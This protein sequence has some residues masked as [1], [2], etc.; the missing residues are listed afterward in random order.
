MKLFMNA[1]H[2][3]ISLAVTL[4]IGVITACSE[5]EP[6]GTDYDIKWPVPTI[7]AIS[8]MDSA[9]VSSE[10]TITGTGLDQILTL[11]VDN[12]TMTI[13]EKTGTS[14]KATLPRKFNASKLTMTNVYRQTII[15]NDVLSPKYPA[16]DIVSFPDSIFVNEPIVITGSNLDL[17][18]SVLIGANIV[19]VS[20]SSAES[21]TVPTVGLKIKDGDQI[22]I[23]VKSTFSKV[24]NSESELLPVSMH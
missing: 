22:V 13:G 3:L 19:A 6:Y 2:I 5:E 10:I 12:R 14:L 23:E 15:S 21:L 7:S 4:C 16:I 8:P 20:S 17:A 11:T 24:V 1:K 9:T 18:T